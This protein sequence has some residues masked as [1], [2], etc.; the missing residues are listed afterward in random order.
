M[1]RIFRSVLGSAVLCLQ[2]L[3]AAAQ[4]PIPWAVMSH[5]EEW[6][7]EASAR[8][9]DATRCSLAPPNQQDCSPTVACTYV[10]RRTG[11]RSITVPAT[12]ENDCSYDL[13]ALLRW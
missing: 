8:P 2:S 9:P 13:K 5:V 3:S 4:I 11:Q 10:N 7:F 1:D 12:N 6:G